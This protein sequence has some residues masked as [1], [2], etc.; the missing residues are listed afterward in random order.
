MHLLCI[1]Y[2]PDV[3]LDPGW[4][5]LFLADL[6]EDIF[7]IDLRSYDIHVDLI[8]DRRSYLKCIQETDA[9][10]G[11]VVIFGS[12]ILANFEAHFI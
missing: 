1:S 5:I 7:E 11:F 8:L 4:D 2:F 10:Y 12:G 9:F 6:E 3:S